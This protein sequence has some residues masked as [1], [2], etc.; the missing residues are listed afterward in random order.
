MCDVYVDRKMSD[1][2]EGRVVQ[3]DV[4]KTARRSVTD[5]VLSPD[6]KLEDNLRNFREYHQIFEPTH[7]LG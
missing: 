7:Q 4:R 2:D 1:V 5:N 3:A 6:L